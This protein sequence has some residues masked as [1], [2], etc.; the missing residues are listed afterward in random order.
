MLVQQKNLRA[1]AEFLIVGVCTLAFALT[2]GVICGKLLGRNATGTRDFVSYWAAGQQLVHHANPYDADAI[3][4]IERS[5]GFPR[6]LS[7]LIMR[8]PPSALLLALPLGFFGPRTGL[9]LWE[10]LLLACLVASVRT[11]WIMYGR[12]KGQ[13]NLFAY[14]FAPALVCLLGGQTALF[15]LLGLVGFLHLHR[16]CP[17]LA[18]VSLWLCAL[19]P[20]LLL[21]FCFALLV[22][23][24]ITRS[25]KILAGTAVALCVSTAIALIL[26]P[27]AWVHYRQM[28]GAAQVNILAIPCLSVRLGRI[29][30]PHS[31]LIQYLPATFGCVWALAYFRKHYDEWDWMEHGSRLILVSAV[32]APY[33]WITDQAIL[34]PALLH[35]V[36]LTRLR[37]LLAVLALA[38]AVIEIGILRGIPE[39]D[40]AFYIWTA[41]GWL[42]WYLYATK[43]RCAMDAYEPLRH[44]DG[45]LMGKVKD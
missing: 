30:S 32:V 6:E 2:I 16:T 34:I 26:D 24:I 7:A 17:F 38:S 5:V 31:L 12:P 27:L 15:A 22:W 3:L 13:L 44:T 41:P 19:K 10:L 43:P 11:V 29:V 33:A 37:G 18:G 28:L 45:A 14:S 23:A 42:V 20:H 25:Y 8:N 9:L 21:P 4:R 36:Y 35:G 40:S 39:F 1:I